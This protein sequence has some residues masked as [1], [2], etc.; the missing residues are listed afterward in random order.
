MINKNA[1]KKGV[2]RKQKGDKSK[3]RETKRTQ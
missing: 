2:K 1:D 3:R